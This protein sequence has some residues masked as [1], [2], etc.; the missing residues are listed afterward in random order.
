MVNSAND[1]LQ[2]SASMTR[3]CEF[4][5]LT[6]RIHRELVDKLDLSRIGD[7]Q[8]DSL[9]QEVRCV[10]EQEC[11]K[12][13]HEEKTPLNSCEREIIIEAV[14]DETFG[15]GPLEI[16]LKE[17]GNSAT[18]VKGPKEVY[19]LREEREHR[20]GVTFR[21][22][23]HLTQIIERI[24]SRDGNQ[25]NVPFPLLQSDEDC[26]VIRYLDSNLSKLEVSLIRWSP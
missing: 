13:C 5:N 4:Q 21:D 3:E 1:D 17:F 24:A 19:V 15:F 9:R 26:I 22:K 8:G 12:V 2:S 23:D 14:L 16:L 6:Q 10:A 7:L 25:V 18:L 20:T 11:D